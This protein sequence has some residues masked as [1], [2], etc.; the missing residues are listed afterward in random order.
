MLSLVIA[1]DPIYKAICTPVATVD[2][3][4]RAQL[5][6]MMD[7]LREEHAMGLGAP[8]VGLTQRLVVVE[9]KDEDGVVH[10]YQMVNPV[11]TR[12]SDEKRT[13]MEASITFLGVSAEVTRPTEITVAYLDEN[14]ASQTL[15]ASGMLATC[16][17]HEIDY[18]DGRTF[19]DHQPPVKRDML[20]RKVEKGKRMGLRPHIHGPH[21][22]H[23]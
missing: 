5:S 4:V 9:L 23:G 10:S 16:L 18:L 22:A 11:I 7:I 8:M 6:E 1:P 15:D 17:Q 13:T 2:D 19:L 3:R 20:K 12:Y 14:G 21:C